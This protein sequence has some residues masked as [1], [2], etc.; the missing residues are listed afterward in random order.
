MGI[1]PFAALPWALQGRRKGEKQGL[2]NP[3]LPGLEGL[4]GKSGPAPEKLAPS[5][6]PTPG[7]SKGSFWKSP[8]VKT[9]APF[10]QPWVISMAQTEEVLTSLPILP[11]CDVPP[12][13]A[14]GRPCL[15][16]SLAAP[17]T[18]HFRRT[19]GSAED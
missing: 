18:P 13:P 8:P 10:V 6:P 2:P 5:P 19:L 1:C 9:L 3:L 11:F 12:C 17:P 16:E 7:P 4:L 15:W 14:E